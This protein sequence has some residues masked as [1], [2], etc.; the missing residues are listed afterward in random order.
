MK[1]EQWDIELKKNAIGIN[2]S[3]LAY[4][5][6]FRTLSGQFDAYPELID[7]LICHFRDNGHTVY[8]IPHSYNY[9][10]PED[11]NDDIVACREAFDRLKN[12]DNVVFIDKDLI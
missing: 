9:N 1:P 7:R 3:G 12:K 6:R 11:T 8:L 5:N 2:V 4:S 10:V